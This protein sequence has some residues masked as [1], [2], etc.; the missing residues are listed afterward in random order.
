VTITW[1]AASGAVTGYGAY[2]TNQNGGG[3]DRSATTGPTARSVTFNVDNHG[4]YNGYVYTINAAGN[5][6]AAGGG[7]ACAYYGY[8][9]S[10]NNCDGYTKY[11]LNTDGSCGFY[12]VDTEYDSP[13]CGYVNPCAGC[14]APGAYLSSYC[15]G[16]TL[17]YRYTNGCCGSYDEAVENNSPTCG[18]VANP[19]AGCA[20]RWQNS[21]FDCENCDGNGGCDL[22]RCYHDGCCGQM[23]FCDSYECCN[24]G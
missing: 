14:P 7:A 8:N 16:Y 5:S 4:S 12:R 24:H 19:C 18:Y 3:V 22:V 9:F 1:A 6:S 23:C 20:P 2:L 17:K 10:T 15:D 11:D 13:S 21:K